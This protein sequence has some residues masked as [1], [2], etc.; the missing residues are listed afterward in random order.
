LSAVTLV[1]LAMVLL[2]D[3]RTRWRLSFATGIG[4]AVGLVIVMLPAIGSPGVAFND[5]VVAHL[6]AGQLAQQD[7]AANVALLLLHREEPLEALALI[8]T[9]I[10][11]IRRNT[12]L[13]MP[14]VWAAVSIL[15]ALTYHPLFPH[16]LVMLTVPLALIAAVG[17]GS[18]PDP[19]HA[20]VPP[21]VTTAL[22]LATAGAGIG[23]IASE[24]H[25][26]MVPDLHDTEMAS[27]VDALSR[28]GDFWISDNP[29]AV[30]LANRDLPGP[31]VDP[32]SQ[33]IRSGLLTVNDLEAARVHY[34][35]RWV[36]E[37]SFRLDK[38]PNYG[39]WLTEH[40][41]AVRNLGGGA[42][43]YQAD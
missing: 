21:L 16:H 7:T 42:V 43:I 5:L 38:V 11:L 1:P 33:R 31:L 4:G 2:M 15:A 28:P 41:H 32:S 22:V 35:V 27:A 26:S 36:L 37:D 23:A 10:A 24:V 25:L 3:R 40:F 17:L 13:L 8:A 30:G 29:F 9:V 19:A 6:R 39:T 14:L 34:H 18:H 12:G 20:G